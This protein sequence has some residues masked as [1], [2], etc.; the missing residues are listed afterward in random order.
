MRWIPILLMLATAAAA[1]HQDP[2]GLPSG[3]ASLALATQDSIQGGGIVEG[4]DFYGSAVLTGT[5][6]ELVEGGEVDLIFF[7]L[8]P[9]SE[10]FQLRG[11]E[12][13]DFFDRELLSSLG[14]AVLDTMS[15][16]ES[17]TL[18]V[19]REA[20]EGC[21]Y[22]LLQIR[23]GADP[24]ATAVKFRITHLGVDDIELDWAW[25]PNGSMEFAPSPVAERSLGEVKRTW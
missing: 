4:F 8:D 20:C 17:D 1:D 2:Y 12:G 24:E 14:V 10:G 9:G 5:Y 13:R 22:Y 15:S 11:P 7:D 19:H 18:Y 16:M 21:G 25:Q 3:S 6:A 23:E